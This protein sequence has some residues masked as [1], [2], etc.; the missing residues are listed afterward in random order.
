MAITSPFSI[1]RDEDLGAVSIESEYELDS[2]DEL[3]SL[4][5]FGEN[6]SEDDGNSVKT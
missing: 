5:Q 1:A 4:D 3:D 6:E 2:D